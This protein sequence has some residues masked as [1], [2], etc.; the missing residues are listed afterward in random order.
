MIRAV[1]Y[2][3]GRWDP[4]ARFRIR[5]YIEPLHRIGVDLKEYPAR[6][7][8]YPPVRHVIRPFWAAA[9]VASRIP[10]LLLSHGAEV[11]IFQRSLLSTCLTLEFMGK[12]PRLLDVDDAI[13]LHQRA[14]SVQR[15]AEYSDGVICGNAF[16]AENLQAWNRSVCVLPTAVDTDRYRPS[17][18]SAGRGE[19][20]G[21]TGSSG[22]LRYL[23]S[24]ER[25]L[26]EV[27]ARNPG[28][29]LS[30][31]CDQMP[32]F[33]HIPRDRFSYVRWCPRVEVE[34]LQRLTIGIMPLDDSEWARGKCG[35]KMLTYMACGLPV[36]V[37]PVG[38][39]IEILKKGSLGFGAV[40][41]DDWVDCLD[42]LVRN[43]SRGK[44]YGADGRRVV[45]QDYSVSGLTPRFAQVLRSYAVAV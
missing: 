29:S 27:L 30:V 21:W 42:W 41:N 40:T 1:A 38:S 19:I 25:A 23:Y 13:W 43:P 2:T 17:E 7:G 12:R 10:S 15:L 8:A 9:A 4:S 35:L 37:S 33:S 26:M 18:A 32:H 16:L 22:N 45:L 14:R 20:I 5:Q 44:T 6:F 39:N 28:V 24:I 3:G 31:I 34:A 36:V 11:T